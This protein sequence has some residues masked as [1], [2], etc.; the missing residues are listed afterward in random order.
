[1]LHGVRKKFLNNAVQIQ[2]RIQIQR[3][4]KPAC[5]QT[6]MKRRTLLLLRGKL[7]YRLDQTQIIQQLRPKLM[8]RL[9]GHQN[10]IRHLL[11]HLMKL[12]LHLYVAG[13]F[14]L[15]ISQK[16]LTLT[17]QRNQILQHRIM[18]IQVKSDRCF[19][20]IVNISFL[21]Q[22]GFVSCFFKS[23]R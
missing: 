22:T 14:F 8:A 15:K 18:Q 10:N 9:P 16:Q 17:L 19:S 5:I 4:R 11:I 6:D 2:L 20:S 21:S 7:G 3:R 13:L 23:S 12:V 1:M